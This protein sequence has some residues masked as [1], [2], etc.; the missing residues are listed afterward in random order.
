MQQARGR[1]PSSP[2]AVSGTRGRSDPRGQSDPRG[3]VPPLPAE[4]SARATS[5]NP[6]PGKSQA[7]PGQA[8]Q[9]QQQQQQQRTRSRS[10]SRASTTHSVFPAGDNRNEQPETLH[11]IRNDMMVNHLY[12]QQLRKQYASWTDPY[13]G[14]VLKKARGS[15]TCC[16]PH[17]AAIPDSLF[18]VVS[19]MNVRCA[20]TVNTPVVRALLG[21]LCEGVAAEKKADHVPLPDGLRVQILP[22]M[23]DLPRG[24]LHHF[25]AFVENARLLVVW[26]DE[27][28]KLL[29]RAENLEARFIE[30][31]WGGGEARKNADGDDDADESHPSS[32]TAAG[33][34]RR[35]GSSAHGAADADADLEEAAEHRPV[36][37]ESAVTVA[38]T[39]ALCI[40]CLGLGW[41]ALALE[42]AVDGDYTRWALLVVSPAQMFV[43]LFFFQALV[44]N[45]A[46]IFGPISAVTSNS[47]YYSGRA[48][49]RRLHRRHGQGQLPHVTIQMPVY[50][51]GLAAVIRPTVVSLKAAISTYEMQGGSANIFV[52]DDGMQ[53][54][55]DDEAQA[56]R[57]FYDEH[58]IGWVARPAH[59]PPKPD[60]SKG[61]EAEGE[62][63]F[64]RRGK[65]K[66]ASNMNY[67]LHVSNRVEDKLAGPG[68]AVQRHARWT[69][70]HERAAYYG[71]L[72]AVLAEDAGR[73]WA[74]GN[75]RVGDYILLIDSDTRVP[76][77]CLL[78]AVSEMEQSPE[79]A[80]TQFASGVMNVTD[81]F[82][83]SGVTW[84]TRLIY[85]AITFAVASG[86][87][88]PFVGHNAI[89]RWRALQ[90]AAAYMDEADGYEKYW[91]EAHVSEDF[92]MALRLQVAGYSLRYAAYTGEGFK[93]GVSLTVYDELARWEKYAYGCNELLFHP[94]RF[95]PVRGPFTP[96]F[97]RFLASSI[98]LPKKLTICAY[99]GTYY[100]IAAAWSLSLANYFITGWF[101]GVY[102]KFYLDSFAIYISIIVVFTGL[103]NVALAVLRYRLNEQSLISACFENIKWI[104]MFTIFLG[105]VSLHVSQAILSHFFEL[106]M[107]WGAT[108]KEIE[109]VHF[110][111]EM[112][113]ILRRFKFTF[114]Y[115]FAC[116]AL[117]VAGMFAT[118]YNWRIDA[119]F[120]IYPLAAVVVSH[121]ALPVLLNPALMMFTW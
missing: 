70:E 2:A 62:Q 112:V 5:T 85:T 101:Y 15:F 59:N 71:C 86:D 51:E 25:A 48:P 34:K 56:R 77:D 102:D 96:L 28:E 29:A 105:G 44:G 58:N 47:K 37:L 42:S 36:R 88:C 55:A 79:V 120:S 103:G 82:F 8:G 4:S 24:Q 121:F 16:P 57:D 64:V 60:K 117:I 26:D 107:A 78:D 10:L 111:E 118:P 108:A 38:I 87:A 13:E 68:S 46:Q 66:K 22:T 9:Q 30:M 76:A 33:E 45:L 7:Q 69:D 63:T 61:G 93:E 32:S 1:Q 114:V 3:H 80:I 84:F 54:L 74:D 23:A 90:D 49:R 27:P 35:P 91:S 95:W 83:E 99:I 81:S 116:T 12:E 20:M 98:P 89:L 39:L 40:S 14:V 17:M 52:N 19:A 115:C 104:P 106:D 75:I 53:L 50:K 109:E 100:A 92:D 21:T 31:V 113:R 94:L 18:A 67:A 43:S 72:A 119:F 6:A 11:A 73:T 65:F 41:R 97:R 110:G